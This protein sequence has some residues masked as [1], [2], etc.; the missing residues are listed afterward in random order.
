MTRCR[1]KAVA[2]LWLALS[3]LL[4]GCATVQPQNIFD[5]TPRLVEA[6]R[7][8]SPG[9]APREA[10][11]LAIGLLQNAW[12]LANEYRMSPVPGLHN[13]KVNLGFR[14]RGLCW[15]FAVD[16]I[17]YARSL[18]LRSFDYYWAVAHEGFP[19]KEHS[20]MVVTARG[21]PFETGL[22]MDA[23]RRP[24]RLYWTAVTK[25][26]GYPWRPYI[27]DNANDILNPR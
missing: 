13:V 23:W 19:L 11:Q 4:G 7:A 22:V 26:P 1:P 14:E 3:L 12:E 17:A 2:C 21:E 5:E 8:L 20:V 10:E 16:M 9:V 15:H 6:L 18:G 25:D 24:Y 27:R